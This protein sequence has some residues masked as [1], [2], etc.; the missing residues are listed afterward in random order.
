MHGLQD[1]EIEGKGMHGIQDTEIQG[2]GMHGIR[3]RYKGK[4]RMGYVYD[5][6][7]RDTWDTGYSDTRERD[8][9]DT[10]YRDTAES[11]ALDECML[12]DYVPCIGI[13]TVRTDEA[14][15]A[16]VMLQVWAC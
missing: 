15:P 4:G 8:A 7:E 9:L 10:G 12:T 16:T 3:I 14:K 6:R 11:Y 5:T 1:T 2:K 13:C